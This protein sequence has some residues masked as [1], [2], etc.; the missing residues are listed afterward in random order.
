MI[1]PASRSLLALIIA[2]LAIKPKQL[3]I[4]IRDALKPAPT[5]SPARSSDSNP[6]RSQPRP[7]TAS[8][9]RP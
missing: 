9:A 6:R 1:S 7:P 8:P 2:F 4:L 5:A 3:R